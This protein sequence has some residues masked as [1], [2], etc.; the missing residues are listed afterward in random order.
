M[1]NN[2]PNTAFDFTMEA[3]PAASVRNV[4]NPGEVAAAYSEG[5]VPEQMFALSLVGGHVVSDK[6]AFQSTIAEEGGYNYSIRNHTGQ[7]VAGGA[8]EGNL[9][10]TPTAEVATGKFAP[11]VYF[12]T[13]SSATGKETV[14]FIKK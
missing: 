10:D 11:G 8:F 3:G 12:L 9:F 4:T 5:G 14:K 1:M 6:I 13:L 2:G 7:E